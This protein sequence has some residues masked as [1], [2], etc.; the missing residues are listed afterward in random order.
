MSNP[1][2][3]G[4]GLS[5]RKITPVIIF[6]LLLICFGVAYFVTVVHQLQQAREATAQ[7]WRQLAVLLDRD[8]R[9]FEEAGVDPTVSNADL[10]SN[11]LS[12]SS[13][14]PDKFQQ[15]SALTDQFRTTVDVVAQRSLADA[16]EQFVEESKSQFA[17]DVAASQELTVSVLDYNRTL[18]EERR[19]ATS[20]GGRLVRVFLLIPQL[21]D[22]RLGR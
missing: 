12:D 3:A 14:W 1:L 5:G 2:D 19:I 10:E 18:S 22:F 6:V 16:I 7:Q 4:P 11:S 8:Y 17:V 15:L 13:D 21:G 20:I 9:Q